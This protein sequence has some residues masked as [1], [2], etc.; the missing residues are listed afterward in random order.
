M[1]LTSK[2]LKISTSQSRVSFETS[3]IM[4]A[5]VGGS[6]IES[7]RCYSCTDSVELKSL[8]EPVGKIRTFRVYIDSC[9]SSIKA[10][11]FY[12]NRPFLC[13]GRRGRGSFEWGVL[14]LL[15]RIDWKI[16]PR[17]KRKSNDPS[18]ALLGLYSV[19]KVMMLHEYKLSSKKSKLSWLP[20]GVSRS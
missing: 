5:L 4:N 20:I 14:K 15:C 7:L 3:I 8:R 10:G 2:S 6:Y 1:D 19:L 11:Y 12:L 13:P 18:M 17:L 9:E 16:V